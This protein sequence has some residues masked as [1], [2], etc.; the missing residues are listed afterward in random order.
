MLVMI[1]MSSAC[2]ITERVG[3]IRYAEMMLAGLRQRS[4]RAKLCAS[5]P[6]GQDISG[7]A[8]V[9]EISRRAVLAVG[10]A[11]LTAFWPAALGRRAGATLE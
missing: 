4:L 6:I 3:R 8:V 9:F 10:G 2:P 7:G 5:H 1:T 11:V